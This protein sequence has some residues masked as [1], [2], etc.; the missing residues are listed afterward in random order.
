MGFTGTFLAIQY[1]E[2]CV[3]GN[4]S[5]ISEQTICALIKS[6]TNSKYDNK[7]QSYFLYKQISHI[8]IYIIVH[9]SHLPVYS[10]IISLQTLL[11]ST[12]GNKKR[13]I[14]EALGSLPIDICGPKFE[15]NMNTDI[16]SLS[17]ESFISNY[18]TLVP[19]KVFWK[20]RTLIINLLSQ[21]Y[22]C[23]KFA[24]TEEDFIRLGQEIAW[25]R[26]LNDNPIDD[27]KIDSKAVFNPPV[28]VYID[29]NFYFTFN[30]LPPSIEEN[31]KISNPHLAIAFTTDRNYFDYPNEPTKKIKSTD[32]IQNTFQKC[33]RIMGNMV[34]KG[35]IHT[36]LIPLF[37]NRVQQTRRQ[38]LGIYNWQQG[39]RL[40]QWLNSCRYPNFAVSGI[41]D[42]EHLISIDNSD[43]LHHYIGE[44]ILGF[45]LV[46]ASC[47]RNQAPK[48]K[49]FDENG[50]SIDA[51]YLFNK[52]L[53]NNFICI[54]INTYYFG[55]T[56]KSFHQIDYL[57]NDSF[58]D[59]LIDAMGIDTHMEERVRI[60]DQ[61]NMTETEFKLFFKN[62]GIDDEDI[63]KMNKGIEDIII[64][65]GPHLG[66]FN[67]PISVPKL[68]DLL[69]C[70]SSMCISDRYIMEN[71]LKAS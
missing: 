35:I 37:H 7:K 18:P 3:Q 60:E 22:L 8:L 1:V 68:I 49:G 25:L 11:F 50:V 15:Q 71:R 23:I 66:G 39:G 62:R 21:Q 16:L 26:F 6:I 43:C 32:L 67:Q 51:R 17:F 54:I 48:V 40:D 12:Y 55:I 45:I 58:I 2:S 41:R 36:A 52:P 20:G 64:H 56:G 14:S 28:P 69:F 47:F 5:Q 34:S 38:D 44:H 10:V 42:F 53:F 31:T 13:A 46:L 57:V 59:Q 33:A 30:E 27:N 61:N 70:L 4:T 9:A 29:N 19:N 63:K 65:T 24:R